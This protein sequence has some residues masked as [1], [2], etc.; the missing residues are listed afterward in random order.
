MKVSQ[1]RLRSRPLEREKKNKKA[2]QSQSVRP[3]SWSWIGGAD[4][5]SSSRHTCWSH[6]MMS[7]W[8]NFPPVRACVRGSDVTG[9]RLE[10][11]CRWPSDR[12]CLCARCVVCEHRPSVRATRCSRT[13]N[14]PVCVNVLP[15][16]PVTLVRFATV[17]LTEGSLSVSTKLW[18]ITLE[19]IIHKFLSVGAI[20]TWAASGLK[21]QL[22]RF[23]AI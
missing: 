21:G 12:E 16:S 10:P 13:V 1:P 14:I 2:K 5:C 20:N 6:Y 18:F 3:C 11:C 9:P 17:A 7:W 15:G 23:I 4:G 8:Y 22:V 19:K